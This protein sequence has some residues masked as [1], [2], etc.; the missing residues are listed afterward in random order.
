MTQFDTRYNKILGESFEL[1]VKNKK[2][3]SEKYKLI[4]ENKRYEQAL[5]EIYLIIDEIK[6]QYDI[7]EIS[8]LEQIQDTISK[9][10]DGN[11][12]HKKDVN[13]G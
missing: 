13:N 9:A 5:N 4:K 8:E 3:E 10:K 11:V 1:A 2:L 7:W 12:P 6:E